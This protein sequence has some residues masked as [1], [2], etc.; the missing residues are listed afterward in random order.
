MKKSL[1]QILSAS[2]FLGF[3]IGQDPGAQDANPLRWS[4]L[5]PDT[6]TMARAWEFPR[7]PRIDSA[8]LSAENIA[9]VR[10]GFDLFTNTSTL[11]RKFSGGTM[12]CNNC[13]PNGGQRE[14]AMPLVGVDRVFPEYNRRS[15]RPF[16]L[17]ERIVGCFMRSL[18][19]SGSMDPDVN[20][21]HENDLDGATLTASSEE[22]GAIAAYIT[23]LSFNRHID[24]TL[25]W[26]GH[27]RVNETSVLPLE[28][29]DPLLGRSLF[30]EKCSNCHGVDGQGVFIGDKRPGPLWGPDSWNDG[31]GA[32]RAYTLAGMIR[33]M[34]PYMDPG[35]LTDAE[36]QHIAAYITS[37]PRPG[38]PFKDRD[39]LKEPIPKDAV[40][41]QQLY[42]T[43]PLS[44]Q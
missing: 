21:R 9:R 37:Q 27:N 33:Y 11:A 8:G 43:N 16:T 4:I 17:E 10:R 40:Y 22:V 2:A 3:A 44:R 30:E 5:V 19:A 41:Y 12:T 7:D 1:L 31:A 26:R 34:M 20:I 42:T 24:P 38:F 14:K 15:G 28:K 35:A 18:N 32:A 25:P 6:A 39:Y 13:H 36:A 23:W 29:L